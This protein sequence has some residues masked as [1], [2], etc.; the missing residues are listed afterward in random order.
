M[1]RFWLF[2]FYTAEEGT[3]YSQA[4]IT[5]RC[6]FL[7]VQLLSAIP[8]SPREDMVLATASH[9]GSGAGRNPT[10]GSQGKQAACEMRDS[11]QWA[12]GLQNQPTLLSLRLGIN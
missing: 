9:V 8:F 10:R 4:Q 1:E 12:W 3:P 11:V 5:D 2:L 7:P 6:D